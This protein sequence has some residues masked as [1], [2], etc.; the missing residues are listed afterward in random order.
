MKWVGVGWAVYADG[1]GWRVYADGVGCNVVEVN[2]VG[3]GETAI[4]LK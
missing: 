3:V 4:I 2:D 1:V